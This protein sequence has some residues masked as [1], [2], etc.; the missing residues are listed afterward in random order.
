M[1]TL[2]VALALL[3][4]WLWP[5]ASAPGAAGLDAAAVAAALGELEAEAETEADAEAEAEAEAS[6]ESVDAASEERG[7]VVHEAVSFPRDHGAHPEARIELWELTALLHDADGEPLRVR[8]SLARLGLAR[9]GLR[10][11]ES[12]SKMLSTQMATQMATQRASQQG[13]DQAVDR[14]ASA[15][16]ADAVFVGELVLMRDDISEASATREQRISR[17]ALG[18]AGAGAD[19]AGVERVW[20]E[21]WGL[22]RAT[23]GSWV[24]RAEANDVELELGLS[25][26]K[27]PVV[28]DQQALAGAS[29][30]AGVQGG[31]ASMRF[32][33]QSRLAAAGELRVGALEQDLRGIAWLDH[34]W[35][36]SATVLAGG[37]GQLVANRFRLQLDDGTELTCVYLRRRAGG[38]TPIPS[39]VLIGVDGETLALQRRDLTLEPTEDGWVREDE[40]AYPLGWRLLIPARELDLSIEPLFDRNGSGPPV[41]P[42]ADAWRGA[43][44]VRGWRGA[45]AIGGQGWIDLNGYAEG[46]AL[47]T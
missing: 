21:Q 45:D 14:R 44:E 7:D 6:A 32:Y 33:S 19:E 2:V 42:L 31:T 12:G 24:L 18:L 13:R 37:E 26:L 3:A 9:L 36:A 5:G 11:S 34:G 46:G 39:C 30:Q 15:L 17:A 35:G 16:A 43:V 40:A 38:G 28:L 25:A 47:G 23:D 27:P 1:P 20:I 41:M 10:R 4:Y 22:S 8:L 29:G